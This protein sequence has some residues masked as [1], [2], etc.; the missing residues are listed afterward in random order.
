MITFCHA[1]PFH[2]W[3]ALKE[4]IRQTGAQCAE[5]GRL[6]DRVCYAYRER[7][8]EL[9][10]GLPR[11]YAELQQRH[12]ESQRALMEARVQCGE[13]RGRLEALEAAGGR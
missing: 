6:L 10:Q 13:M 2:L 4:I 5:R 8:D 1:D 9:M 12:A 7:M 11:A 3:Q